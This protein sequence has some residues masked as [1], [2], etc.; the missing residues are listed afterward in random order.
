MRGDVSSRQ[1]AIAWDG[2]RCLVVDP[3]FD[4]LDGENAAFEQEPTIL[5]RF[6]EGF[7]RLGH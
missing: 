7:V 3:E 4:E 2:P 5:L 1:R 6:A